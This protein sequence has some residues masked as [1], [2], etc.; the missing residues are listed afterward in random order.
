MLQ[1]LELDSISSDCE[2][3]VHGGGLDVP[4]RAPRDNGSSPRYVRERVPKDDAINGRESL[5]GLDAD[6]RSARQ[7][8]Q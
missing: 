7:I 6:G 4:S 5:D 8:T 2:R 1:E 3:A